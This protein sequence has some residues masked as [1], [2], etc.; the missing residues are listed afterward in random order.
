MLTA[1]VDLGTNTFNLLIADVKG[2]KF[3]V[4]YA[5]REVVKLGENSINE[6]KICEAAFERGINS[7]KNLA[8]IIKRH[9]PKIIKALATSAIR[10]ADNGKNFINELKKQTGID[11][12]VISGEKEAELIFYGNR[13][14]VQIGNELHLIMDIGGGSTE[15]II[16]NNETIFW[17]QSFKLGVARLLEK[18]KP[19]N[20][21][22]PET[23]QS[24]N[25]YLKEELQ[26]LLLM[27]KKN[28]INC[29]IG[30]AGVFET[31]IDMIGKENCGTG[32]SWYE[33]DIEDYYLI[34]KK[35]IASTAQQRELMPGLIP[36]R[37]DMI[38]LSYLLIDFVVNNSH[39]KQ[40][41]VSMYSLKEGSLV[42][43]INSTNC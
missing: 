4:V 27:L 29:L 23:I 43:I 19:E 12:E 31:V 33:I 30:S 1:I 34:S 5:G 42:E 20:P 40:F 3:R 17:K 28:K 6:N 2:R 41:K 22:K 25:D 36:M 14:A 32:K 39:L 10:E 18:F 15:F 7:F 26:P 35:T 21:V 24:I 37:R 13:L 11:V 9:Q 16:A 38:V 8:H